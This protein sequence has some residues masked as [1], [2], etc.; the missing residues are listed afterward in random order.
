MIEEHGRGIGGLG[1]WGPLD[2]TN[3]KSNGIWGEV[4]GGVSYPPFYGASRVLV[5]CGSSHV[6]YSMIGC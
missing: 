1:D 4:G 3:R 6:A 5:G 2:L